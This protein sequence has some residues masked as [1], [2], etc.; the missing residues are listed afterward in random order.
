M[1]AANSQTPS[2]LMDGEMQRAIEV[3][4]LKACINDLIGV[5]ALPA[6]WSGGEPP[7][8]AGILLDVLLG[9]LRL[10]FAYLLLNDPIG[11][12]TLELVRVAEPG[13]VPERSRDIGEMLGHRLGSDPQRWPAVA[14]I[15]LGDGAVSLAILQL[16]LQGAAGV[17]VAG[18]RRDDFPAQTERLILNVASNQAVMGV[19]ESRLMRELKR[20]ADDLDRRVAQRTGELAAANEE[21]RRE[22]A[23][24]RL[25]EERLRRSEQELRLLIETMPAMVWRATPAG[26]PDYINQR[27][28]DYL[29]RT[30]T[31]L[32]QQRWEEIL[33][34]EDVDSAARDWGIALETEG[35]LAGQ[36][37]FRRADGVYR[38]FQYHSEPLRD[39]DGRVVHW[40]G[41]QVD[42]DD[43][44]KAEETLRTTQTKLSRAS[45]IA[46]VAELAASIAHEISQPLAALVANAHASLRWMS[47]DPPNLERAQL[48]AERIIRDGNAAADVVSRIRALFKRTDSTRARLDVNEVIDEVSRLIAGEASSLNVAI[49]TDLE[50]DLPPIL[51]DRV[52]MQQLIANLA[53]NGIDAMESADGSARMLSIRSRRDGTNGLLIEISDLGRGLEDAE[54]VFEPFFTTKDKGMGMGLAICRWIVEAHHG[55]L[56][57]AP[58]IPRG[59][60]F[61]FTLPTISQ[62]AS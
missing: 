14:R 6:I 1:P 42:I 10:D 55:R 32:T 22:I 38:W 60:T 20:V 56:W 7:R 45:E 62:A 34:P 24:R 53:R 57:G 25:V 41:V 16:G 51:A 52:Q 29:G 19:Q 43:H 35:S 47:A 54:R 23:E 31:D 9:I 40:Y 44:K 26:E 17:I 49:G 58:N 2:P 36:Y 8:I 28:A 3:K 33:H 4:H 46:T 5:V 11:G 39:I 18:S 61:S 37:R 15:P 50:P 30:A 13:Q 59:A 48:T 12:T 27:L 21:L